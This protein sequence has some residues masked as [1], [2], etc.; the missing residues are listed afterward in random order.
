MTR[1]ALIKKQNV[2]TGVIL[3]LHVYVMHEGTETNKIKI[4][5][6]YRE[7]LA[8]IILAGLCSQ[9]CRVGK[10]L[11]FFSYHV[12]KYIH[13]ANITCTVFNQ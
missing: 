9:I 1:A 6:I 2:F 12:I 3:V 11:N 8:G 7:T 13:L 5:A 10:S 4:G